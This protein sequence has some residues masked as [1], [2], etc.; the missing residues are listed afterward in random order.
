M[1]RMMRVTMARATTRRLHLHLP[2]RRAPPPPLPERRASALLLHRWQSRVPRGNVPRGL[3]QL[4]RA[5]AQA[6]S[7]QRQAA[8]SRR[9]LR[10]P[11]R[12]PSPGPNETTRRYSMRVSDHSFVL[13]LSHSVVRIAI[14]RASGGAPP[15]GEPKHRNRTQT[16]KKVEIGVL[17]LK[18]SLG[19]GSKK[20]TI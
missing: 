13:I 11:S 18:F 12:R 2:L 4:T 9:R 7:V 19:L 10:W 16:V 6:Q 14:F 8:A 20:T 1:M 5:A 15:G 3:K 17:P